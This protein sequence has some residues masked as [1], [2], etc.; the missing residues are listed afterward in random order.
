MRVHVHVCVCARVCVCVR[1]R[2]CACVRTSVC[3][4]VWA[5]LC[6]FADRFSSTRS[7][8]AV[9][10]LLLQYIS[11]SLSWSEFY[12]ATIIWRSQIKCLKRRLPDISKID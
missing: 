4:Y 7:S 9:V 3:V 11:S 6:D 8:P 5:F 10:L 2:V 12:P 1:L